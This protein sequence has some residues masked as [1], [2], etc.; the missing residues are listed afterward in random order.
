M[1]NF[2]LAVI[3]ILIDIVFENSSIITI[4]ANQLLMEGGS[5]YREK[6]STNPHYPTH[7]PSMRSPDLRQ[8]VRTTFDHPANEAATTHTNIQTDTHTHM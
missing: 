1:P 5:V 6:T 3:H 4:L 8:P 2:E 7:M